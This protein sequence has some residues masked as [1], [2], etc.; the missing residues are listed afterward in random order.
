MDKEEQIELHLNS[1]MR[2]RVLRALKLCELPDRELKEGN[3][4]GMGAREQIQFSRDYYG[5]ILI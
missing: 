4:L 5:I 1:I 2:E 3:L